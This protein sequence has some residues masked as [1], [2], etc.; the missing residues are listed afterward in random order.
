MTRTLLALSL[1]LTTTLGILGCKQENPAAPASAEA[2]VAEEAVLTSFYPTAY[3]ARRIA[4]GLVTVDCPVPEGED[5]IF[6]QPPRPA[7]ERYQGARLIVLNG[8]EFEKWASTASLPASRVV[9][10]AEGFRD[11]YVTFDTGITHSHGPAGEHS[12]EGIDG[13][14]W[15]DPINAIEQ[16]RAI[17]EGM[18][19]AWP[20][21]AQA[22]DANLAL[23]VSDLTALDA[24]FKALTPK[25]EGVRLIASHPAYN[26]L[27][28]RYGWSITNLDLDP[29]AGLT[30]EAMEEIAEAIGSHEGQA[31]LLWESAPSESGFEAPCPSIVFSPAELAATGSNEPE[32][33]YLDIM[34]GNLSRLESALQ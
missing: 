12:H 34:R 25:L 31:V 23:L 1:G 15:L 8:A 19:R 33:D 28:K 10:S 17:A 13:H 18:K 26:Y 11:R 5:P 24:S 22:F 4:G 20:E 6:W 2:S 9:R 7:L 3:F 21:H 16:S 27:A 30:A 29:E 14:T 32:E